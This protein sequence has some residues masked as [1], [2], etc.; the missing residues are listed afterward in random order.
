LDSRRLDA[1]NVRRDYGE[2][3]RV[4]LGE[5]EGRLFVVAYTR[6]GSVVRLVSARKANGRER[7]KY[8]E[9]ISA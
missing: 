4:T 1:E 2:P 5:I 3:R 7:S 8:N 9:A 6:R